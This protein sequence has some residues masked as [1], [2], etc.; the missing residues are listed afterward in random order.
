MKYDID[1]IIVLD[2]D[3][4]LNSHQ[5]LFI[6]WA[7]HLGLSFSY[8]NL[9]KNGPTKKDWDRM[10]KK[11]PLCEKIGFPPML[12]ENM[13]LDR[14]AVYVFNKIVE[15]SGA[16]V[17]ICSSWRGG[18]ELNELRKLLINEHGLKCEIIGKTPYMWETH[19]KYEQNGEWYEPPICSYP[20]YS[21]YR[22]GEEILWWLNEHAPNVKNIAILD[23]SCKMDIIQLFPDHCVIP[24]GNGGL[25]WKFYQQALEILEKPINV[26]EMYEKIK[27]ENKNLNAEYSEK[28]S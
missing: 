2:I 7:R 18:R 11:R 13:P 28:K 6:M 27:S 9:Y 8:K 24:S 23:D 3:E 26:V 14:Q 16:K 15:K 22:R 19:P 5:S 21:G 20:F 4:V 25:K 10:F 1:K 12:S 17:L